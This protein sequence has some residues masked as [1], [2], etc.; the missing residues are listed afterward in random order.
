M[1]HVSFKDGCKGYFILYLVS[2]ACMVGDPTAFVM[3]YDRETV[4]VKREFGIRGDWV[5]V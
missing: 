5:E 3:R 2:G 4:Y 1:V